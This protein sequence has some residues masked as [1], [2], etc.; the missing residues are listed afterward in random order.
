[1]L[2]QQPPFLREELWGAEAHT[3]QAIVLTASDFWDIFVIGEP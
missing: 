3:H 1:M 2:P